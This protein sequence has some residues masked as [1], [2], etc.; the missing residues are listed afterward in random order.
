MG[1]PMCTFNNIN[2]FT[3]KPSIHDTFS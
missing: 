2:N 1:I 3:T